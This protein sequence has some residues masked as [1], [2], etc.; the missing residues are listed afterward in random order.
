MSLK[1]TWVG[2]QDNNYQYLQHVW[3][4]AV[5]NTPGQLRGKELIFWDGNWERTKARLMEEN[6]RMS[7]SYGL[8]GAQKAYIY[9]LKSINPRQAKYSEDLDCR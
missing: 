4:A 5:R 2:N 3:A 6:K 9:Y 8:I 1:S 7:V